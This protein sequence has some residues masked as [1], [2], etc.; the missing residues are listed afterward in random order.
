M[1]QEFGR[2][3]RLRARAQFTAVQDKGRRVS[4]RY[5]TLLGMTNALGRDRLGIIASRRV[6]DAVTRNRAK[7]RLREIFRQG[8]PDVLVPGQP[9]LDIVAI[10]RGQLAS[11]PVADVRADF[12]T[13][14]RKLRGLVQ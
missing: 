11:A 4:S 14:L 13:A 8:E 5:L 7:R 9:A 1:S 12:Q 2:D 10:A 6:G 3:V